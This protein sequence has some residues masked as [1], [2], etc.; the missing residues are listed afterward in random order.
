MSGTV[1]NIGI[2]TD[3]DGR[4]VLRVTIDYRNGDAPD[5]RWEVVF[6]Q[7]PVDIV[8]AEPKAAPP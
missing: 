5:L 8:L 3:E 2:T 7:T 4:E 1:K 6:E